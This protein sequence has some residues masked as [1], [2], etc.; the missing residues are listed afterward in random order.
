MPAAVIGAIISA[1][2]T[3]GGTI[4][5]VKKSQQAADASLQA[6]RE[7]TAAQTKSNDKALSY[8]YAADEA[9]RRANYDQWAAREGRLSTLGGML[10][11]PARNIPAYVPEP[12]PGAQPDRY[13]S[14]VIG[15]PTGSAAA[16]AP[17]AGGTSNGLNL[18]K[19][20]TAKGL[21]GQA[22]VDWINAQAP[23]SAVVV[24]AGSA[25]PPGKVVWYDKG[26]GQGKFQMVGPENWE[27]KIDPALG[28][29]WVYNPLSGATGAPGS[30]RVPYAGSNT[31]A[32]NAPS[33]VSLAQ[34]R[35]APRRFVP[36]SVGAVM[37]A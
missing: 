28:E 8:Q 7:T 27:Y 1:A 30:A 22:A 34:Y 13:G 2:A 15:A 35:P 11:L 3:T 19:Q 32:A 20:A 23:G 26:N 37:G 9:N 17:A 14:T 25:S 4:Y 33:P 36:G 21:Q 18:V 12:D 29:G 16:T 31:Y 10:G 6:E 5:A 24:P